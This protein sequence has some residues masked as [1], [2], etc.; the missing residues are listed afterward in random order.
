MT[1]STAEPGPATSLIDAVDALL[2]TLVADLERLV[3]IPSIAFPDFP[4]EPLL[5]AHDLVVQLL[6]DAGVEHI[7]DLHVEGKRAPVI[8]AS[9]PGPAG[10]PTVL[11]YTHY[12]VV[13]AGDLELWDS[14]PF[15]PT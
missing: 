10:A 2:P 8:T 4:T 3:R 12:D 15:E 14:P 13:P 9:I 7:E 5:A 11:L 1:T 6:R